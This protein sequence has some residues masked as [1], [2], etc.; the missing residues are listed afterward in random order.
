ME[1]HET[2][3]HFLRKPICSKIDD[4]IKEMPHLE[5]VVIKE[6]E[7]NFDKSWFSLLWTCQR[8]SKPLN[9][10]QVLEIET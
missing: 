3:P 5:N 8:V 10:L 6:G 7:F 9:S 2:E 4:L 1:Y